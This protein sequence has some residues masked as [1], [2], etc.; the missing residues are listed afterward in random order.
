MPRTFFVYMLASKPR[1]TL[2]TGVTGD[3]MQ[4]IWQHR[5]GA[6]PGFTDEYGVKRLVWYEQHETAA[7]AIHREKRLKKWRRDWK[8]ALIEQTNL[9]WDDLYDRLGP[10]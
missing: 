9:A 2:Y 8:V 10:A 5:T 6:Y 4:R 3:L 7:T 1:G